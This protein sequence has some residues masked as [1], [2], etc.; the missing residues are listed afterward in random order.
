MYRDIPD[1][2]R[3]LIEPLAQDHGLELVDVAFHRGR[4]PHRLVV[5]VDTPTGDGRVPIDDCAALSRELSI[6]LDANEQFDVRYT[7]EV[8]SPGLD[9]VLGREKDF[10][11]VCGQTIKLVT[12]EPR[13]GSRKFRGKLVAFDKG[14]ATILVDGTERVIPFSDVVRAHSVYEFSREDFAKA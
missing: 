12:R 13:F 1:D 4:A 7:L 11:K 2:L 6:H 9:R 8:T 3:R 10:E 5:V 14:D